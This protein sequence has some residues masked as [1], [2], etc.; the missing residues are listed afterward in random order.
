MRS[1]CRTGD[2]IQGITIDN[3]DSAITISDWQL[4]YASREWIWT[5]LTRATNFKN[6]YFRRGRLEEFDQSRLR[7][8]LEQMAT[9][10]RIKRLSE[11]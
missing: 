7:S 4:F 5:A 8:Y 9:K 11:K 3:D 2:S 10:I 6:V 1:Y